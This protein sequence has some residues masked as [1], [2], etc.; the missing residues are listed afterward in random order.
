M[1]DFKLQINDPFSDCTAIS[2][3]SRA[4]AIEDGILVDVTKQAKELGFKYPVAVTNNVWASCISWD[5]EKEKAV[6]DEAGRL[7][8]VLWIAMITAKR[9]KGEQAFFD[10]FHIPNGGMLPSPVT[11]KSVCGPG[12]KAEP[13]IT[14]MRPWED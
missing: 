11:L 6:Q 2:I 3:Y 7:Y 10:V 14:I 1:S 13:V 5:A 9:T 4:Q 8:D 12:D